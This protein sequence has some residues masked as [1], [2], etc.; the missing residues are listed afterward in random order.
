MRKGISCV[1]FLACLICA[2]GIC[3]AENGDLN[4]YQQKV[5]AWAA[6][7]LV[8]APGAASAH[9]RLFRPYDLGHPDP[10]L[11]PGI[12]TLE[13]TYQ[14]MPLAKCAAP[15]LAKDVRGISTKLA[16]AGEGKML[17]ARATQL[18]PTGVA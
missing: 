13:L 6:A 15:I 7:N 12:Q 17:I 10:R 2:P 9:E 5:V 8:S 3:S 18:V 1:S 16:E 14:V 11:A 4:P